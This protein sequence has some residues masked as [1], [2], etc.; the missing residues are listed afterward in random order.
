M[1]PCLRH[2]PSG[3]LDTVLLKVYSLLSI[4][5][6]KSRSTGRQKEPAPEET[7]E[8]VFGVF[9]REAGV[10]LKQG[11]TSNEIGKHTQTKVQNLPGQ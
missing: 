1:A 11:G 8:S 9:L 3:D 6:K 4:E 5:A 2:C 7:N 10:T